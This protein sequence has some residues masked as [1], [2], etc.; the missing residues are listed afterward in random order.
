MKSKT[1]LRAA[2]TVRALE[3]IASEMGAW[4]ADDFNV[5]MLPNFS[6]GESQQ[7][8]SGSVVVDRPPFNY[9]WAGTEK[10]NALA[11]RAL[12]VKLPASRERNYAWLC[13]VERETLAAALL[14]ELFSVT[15]C[16]AFAGLGKV[17]D[18]AFLTLDEGEVG[19]IRAA[20]LQWLDGAAA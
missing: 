15:G 19:Q 12:Q 13:G 11:T 17:A 3:V 16:V 9:E 6:A 8:L 18:L 10:F 5:Q 14:V 1:E 20:M 4:S 7:T 2:A